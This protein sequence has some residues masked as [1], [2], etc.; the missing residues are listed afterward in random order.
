MSE[1]GQGMVYLDYGIQS[2]SHDKGNILVLQE[3][4]A[5]GGWL[6]AVGVWGVLKFWISQHFILYPNRSLFVYVFNVGY[7]SVCFLQKENIAQL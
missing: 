6:K 4:G 5:G 2:E 7:M 1:Y 3:M